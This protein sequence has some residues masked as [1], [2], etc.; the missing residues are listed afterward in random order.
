MVLHE[1]TTNAVKY[2]AL[3]NMTG[4]INIG[5]R[6]IER[7]GY[8]IELTWEESG[9]PVVKHHSGGF[10]TKLIRRVLS[11]QKAEIE[12]DFDPKG[13]RCTLAVPLPSASNA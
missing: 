12:I 6:L 4:N 11:D 3:S 1:L 2:G 9:G 13:L 8:Q 10:G 7:N 5:W